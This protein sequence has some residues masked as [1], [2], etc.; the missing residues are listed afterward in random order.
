[1]SD[2]KILLVE[3][4]SI[5][6]M[7]IKRTL[8]SFGYEVPYVAS[9]SEKAVEKALTVMPDLI[10]MD[11]ILKGE[12]DGIETVSKIKDLNIPVIYL[13]AHS[14]EST[15]ERAKFT[16]P[17]GYIIKP[18]DRN[19]LK[20]AIE[21]AIYK[22]KMEKRLKVS[23]KLYRSIIETT[24]EG[25]A[26]D[27]PEGGFTY[28]NNRFQDMI[29][30]KKEEL[31]G[32][33]ILEFMGEDQIPLIKN[34]R[35]RIYD[36]EKFEIQC[37]F[38]RKDGSILWTIAQFSPMYD[39]NGKHIANLAMHTD[40]TERKKSEK[41]LTVQA[42]MLANINEAV[43]GTDVNYLI[44]YWNKSAE[45]MYGYSEEEI[46][47]Q[48]SGIL[49]PEFFGLTNQEALKQL[50]TTGNLNVELIHTTKDGRKIIVDSRNQTLSDQ[51]GNRYGMIGINRDITERKKADEELKLVSLYNRSLIEASLDPLVTI[52]PDGRINDVNKATETVTGYSRDELIGSV[53]SDYFTEPV[54]AKDGY[55][56]VFKEGLVRDYPLE[57]QHK[58]GHVT[59]VL[60]NASV[61]RDE[62]G[63]VV[64]VFAAARDMTE[65]KK[66]E[67]ALRKSEEKYRDIF[68][69]SFDGLFITS[70]EGKIL[71]MNKKGI[72]MLGYNTKEEILNLDLA[73]D[74]YADPNDRKKI[75]AI[76]NEQGSAEYE[77]VVKKK[78]GDKIIT[79]CSLTAVKDKGVITTYRGI[80][81]DITKSK[82]AEEERDRFF[83]LS[84]DMLC[85]GDFNGYFIQLNPSWEK[86]LGWT[87]N[88]LMSKPY[89]KFVHPDDQEST[90]E[91][92]QKLADGQNV[93]E[94]E[95]RYLCKDGSYRWLSWKAFPIY[96]EIIYA[97]ARD[98]TQTKE[99]EKQI[100]KS[101][102]EKDMLLKE[103][104]HRVKNNLM[105][106]SSLLNLQSGYI[107]DKASRD[108]FKESQN[109]ARSMALIH[110]RLYQST[111][112]KS[113]DFG[114]Y[115]TSLSN[116]L[117]HTYVADSGFIV[118]EINVEDIFLDINTAIPLGLIVNEL[119]TNSLKH[120][121]P[122][123]MKGKI[124]IEFQ[125]VDEHYEFIVKD[126]GIGFP[127]ELD[128]QN[129]ESLGLQ[130]VT[131]LTNQIDGKI[132][133]DRNK[134]TKF[135][136]TFKDSEL[137]ER[138]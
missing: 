93:I 111:D 69:E 131:S 45:K 119:V 101:L 114:E 19:E 16:E 26:I 71:D 12:T 1:M 36:G 63:N 32:H 53:F 115:I 30:F 99:A 72:E 133:L 14:E 42:I 82:K 4:E 117:F 122:N 108:I 136:I 91:A 68:E 24:H 54:K 2:V 60:Y 35:Q 6:A 125:S 55:R 56:Q 104:H 40:I 20:Y 88:E 79:R 135:K 74:V 87:T 137:L 92:V 25:V 118:L 81:R 90:A 27:A 109:R 13:T 62:S 138:L 129:T 98:M 73:T 70:P 95:N 100:Q 51:F 124:N 89:M 113:I 105:I 67:D 107:K 8:E 34:S 46:I 116:E 112:L 41:K 59:P 94:F 22:N 3:D 31:I 50:E 120:A 127:E 96:P 66:A 33:D 48:Y 52:G 86:T 10:L 21:L 110:E 15:I 128:Y 78:N 64:G 44:N 103:I 39:G 29:G 9:N 97:L 126:N 17:Y 18:Y 121:F 76:V 84:L 77:L 85:I 80:I 47:G 49:K 83:N 43:I 123:S 130:M 102:A 134:G 37:K 65:H 57:I 28:V 58:D 38:H 23:E 106:I 61:Y 5:E 75:L 7:D 11:I 132:E